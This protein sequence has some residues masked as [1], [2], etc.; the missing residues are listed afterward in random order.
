M[1]GLYSGLT[2]TAPTENKD[3]HCGGRA[4]GGHAR[5]HDRYWVMTERGSG[6]GD[7][8]LATFSETK[9]NDTTQSCSTGRNIQGSTKDYIYREWIEF[10][11]LGPCPI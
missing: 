6:I 9:G 7:Q 2:E 3:S 11:Q 1:R 10:K 5:K 8:D 4:G